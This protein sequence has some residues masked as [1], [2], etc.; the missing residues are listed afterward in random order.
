M[1]GSLPLTS[2]TIRGANPAAPNELCRFLGLAGLHGVRCSERCGCRQPF[3]PEVGDHDVGA[4][5]GE[6]R[7]SG[8]RRSHRHR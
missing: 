5:L 1:P 3:G 6:Q 8:K 7:T 4:E 2:Y